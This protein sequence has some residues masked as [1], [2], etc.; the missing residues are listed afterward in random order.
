MAKN[1]PIASTAG[2]VAKGA[3]TGAAIGSFVPGVGTL[4]GAGI[5]ALGGLGVGILTL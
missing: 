3:A 1:K 2:T 4:L 5:G